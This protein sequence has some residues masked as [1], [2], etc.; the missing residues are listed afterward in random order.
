[1]LNGN[2]IKD[3]FK[4]CMK[5]PIIVKCMKMEDEFVVDTL[6][7]IMFGKKGDYLMEGIKGERYPCKA[8]IFELTYD[9]L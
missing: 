8:I 4:N 1:M 5:K 6:E 3:G 7:G 9:L 2:E